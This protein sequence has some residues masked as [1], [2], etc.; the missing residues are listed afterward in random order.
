MGCNAEGCVK[1]MYYLHQI[2]KNHFVKKLCE[3]HARKITSDDTSIKIQTL[4]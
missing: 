3:N 2:P 4:S 1:L